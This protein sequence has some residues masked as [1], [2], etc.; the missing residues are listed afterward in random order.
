MRG[1]YPIVD[2]DVL[3]QRGFAVV[4][5]AERVLA[6][7]PELLQLRAKHASGRDTLALLRALRPLCTAAG[8]LLFANDRA[9]LA[10]LADCDGVHVGQ[11]DLTI[12]E[13]RALA[14]R[15]K[16]GVSTHDIEQLTI[17]LAERP[18]YV[19]FGPIFRTGSKENA[20][21]TVGLTGL[22]RAAERAKA[23]ATPLVAIGGISLESAPLVGE[24]GALAAVIA[25]LIPASGELA[26][27]ADL[28]AA[29]QRA[30]TRDSAPA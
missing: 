18:D 25:A 16:I 12:A 11:H 26:G 19:A 5:F 7:K 4:E 6:A 24:S 13:V 17:A 20:D 3:N 29:L 22:A 2:V 8:C 15:L 9:D 28:A 23:A 14:P 1:L 10:L 27:V 21:P 30:L